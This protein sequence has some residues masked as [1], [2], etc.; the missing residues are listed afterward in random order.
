[1]NLIILHT[2]QWSPST[3]RS[4]LKYILYHLNLGGSAVIPNSKAVFVYRISSN[5]LGMFVLRRR[6]A[7]AYRKK[8]TTH[9]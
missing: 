5:T 9:V 4:A 8:I 2:Q 1:M 7:V 3:L 6:S